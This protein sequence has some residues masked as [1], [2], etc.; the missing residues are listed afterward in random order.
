[1]IW[2]VWDYGV[3]NKTTGQAKFL[4]ELEARNFE[5]VSSLVH[6]SFPDATSP[7]VF[8]ENGQRGFVSG[9]GN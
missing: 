5:Q 8:G 7:Y 6:Q 9:F 1:M 3:V 2:E 4:G